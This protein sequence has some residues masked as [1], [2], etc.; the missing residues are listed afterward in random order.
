[1]LKKTVNDR[2]IVGGLAENSKSTEA[3]HVQQN[4]EKVGH[5]QNKLNCFI[6]EKKNMDS[7]SILS[8]RRVHFIPKTSKTSPFR[9]K[10]VVVVY[11]L[12]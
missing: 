2:L 4:T 10:V 12:C 8:L 6:K 11:L 7:I 9:F 3:Q 5:L 1:M